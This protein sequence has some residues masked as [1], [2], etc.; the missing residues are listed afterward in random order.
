M[1]T[2][3]LNRIATLKQ[4]VEKLEKTWGLKKASVDIG[5][6]FDSPRV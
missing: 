1:S 5:E 6:P 2:V 4:R 3:L